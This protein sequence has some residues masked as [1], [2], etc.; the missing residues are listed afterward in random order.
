VDVVLYRRLSRRRRLVVVAADVDDVKRSAVTLNLG[1]ARHRLADVTEAMRRPPVRII[2][3]FLL[4][5]H[6]YRRSA[7]EQAPQAVTQVLLRDGVNDSAYSS[8][9]T[10]L[11]RGLTRSVGSTSSSFILQLQYPNVT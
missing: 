7:E 11:S 9:T 5:V 1:L 4:R 2:Y 3:R 8:T 10:R 6:Y